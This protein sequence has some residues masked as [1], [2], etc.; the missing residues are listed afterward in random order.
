[1]PPE[2]HAGGRDDPPGTDHAPA[3]RTVRVLPAAGLLLDRRSGGGRAAILSHPRGPDRRRGD[4]RDRQAL[5]RHPT[6]REPTPAAGPRLRPRGDRTG[7]A[8][9]WSRV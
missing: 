3:A 8:H 1:R 9:T 4:P 2:V 7:G 6:G 5:P